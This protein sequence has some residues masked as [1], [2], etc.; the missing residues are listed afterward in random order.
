MDK[1]A[2]KLLR[3]QEF[4]NLKQEADGRH[5]EPIIAHG[6][7]MSWAGILRPGNEFAPAKKSQLA[8]ITG[9][10]S[11]SVKRYFGNWNSS[12][13]RFTTNLTSPN[14]RVEAV[15]PGNRPSDGIQC[16]L[17]WIDS[18]YMIR[19]DKGSVCYGDGWPK[20]LWNAFIF[21]LG[22]VS[23]G[24]TIAEKLR[25]F[26]N[27]DLQETN[28]L[29]SQW[30]RR[31]RAG[32]LVSSEKQL[33]IDRSWLPVP[34]KLVGS[35]ISTQCILSWSPGATFYR[36]LSEAL[37]SREASVKRPDPMNQAK[38]YLECTLAKLHGVS[39]D[40]ADD[41]LEDQ[42]YAQSPGSD[43]NSGFLHQSGEGKNWKSKV[44]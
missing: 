22:S 32:S 35:H 37:A 33:E 15:K 11:N 9:D 16:I 25:S 24:T 23:E 44:R 8:V 20:D 4:R 5:L 1:P 34:A 31:L 6:S 38:Y 3:L 17:H 18:E 36:N 19:S 2:H 7:R 27:S 12:F 13:S 30:H 29:V 43:E 28:E 21:Q 14:I 39:F 40:F 42:K 10:S 26:L 41:L